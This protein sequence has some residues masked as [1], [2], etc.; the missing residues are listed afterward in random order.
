MKIAY[1]E[2]FSDT[3]LQENKQINPKFT[4]CNAPAGY[5]GIPYEAMLLPVNST[6]TLPSNGAISSDC[7]TIS[8]YLRMKLDTTVHIL[9][10]LLYI[11]Y[12]DIIIR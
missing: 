12:P 4:F 2:C 1:L 9:K 11:S 3:F 7:F 6:L 8:V 10:D 5:R